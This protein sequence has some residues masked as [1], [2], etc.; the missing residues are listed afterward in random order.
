MEKRKE[1]D[2]KNKPTLNKNINLFCVEYTCIHC[3]SYFFKIF[4]QILL[5]PTFW[6][7]KSC[8]SL[9]AWY[10]CGRAGRQSLESWSMGSCTHSCSVWYILQCTAQ[11]VRRNIHQGISQSFQY[12]STVSIQYNTV[13][14]VEHTVHH[15]S[16]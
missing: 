15:K 3:I 16:I 1:K 14:E 13:S 9:S 7:W 4:S 5:Q 6:F 10:C 11:S 2:I 12:T 8:S